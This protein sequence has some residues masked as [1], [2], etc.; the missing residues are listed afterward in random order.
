VRGRAVVPSA[1]SDWDVVEAGLP[2]ADKVVVGG[3]RCENVSGRA[4][5][6]I[7]GREISIFQNE[8][9][10]VIPSLEEVVCGKERTLR[11]TTLVDENFTKKTMQT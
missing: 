10:I 7:E 1:P 3:A 6:C 5:T 2:S 9:P 4:E 11:T 8:I